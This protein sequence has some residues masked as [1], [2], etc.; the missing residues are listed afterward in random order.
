M[1]RF[2][3]CLAVLK[4]ALDR[5]DSCALNL[6]YYQRVESFFIFLPIYWWS[7]VLK[8]TCFRSVCFETEIGNKPRNVFLH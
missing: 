8:T 2:L 1:N 7:P 6:E 5:K 3:D 4:Y